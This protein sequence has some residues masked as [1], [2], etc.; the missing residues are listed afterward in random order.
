MDSTTQQVFLIRHGE[1][2]WSRD[3]RHT[4]RTDLPLT[5]EGRR[6]A[7]AIGRALQ[8]RTFRVMVSPLGR[9]RET[10]RLAGCADS[11]RVDDDLREWDYG[12]YEGRTTLDIRREIPDWSVWFSPIVHGESLDQVGAEPFAVAAH[13]HNAGR[14][15][16]ENRLQR[17]P[18]NRGDHR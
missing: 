5:D 7:A 15:V 6:H 18:E 8:G 1:T 17:R 14:A 13:Q 16:S 11:A 4:G 9:A 12:D 2:E 10:C 3:G